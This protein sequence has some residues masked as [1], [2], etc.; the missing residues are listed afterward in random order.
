MVA[1]MIPAG[2]KRGGRP[3]RWIYQVGKQPA[4]LRTKWR[5]LLWV[6]V[7]VKKLRHA[8]KVINR[9]TPPGICSKLDWRVVGPTELLSD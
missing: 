1:K 3:R 8:G 5:K 7:S 2:L 6:M 9:F 4:E